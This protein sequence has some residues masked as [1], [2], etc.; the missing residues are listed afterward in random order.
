MST[1]M[2]QR[3]EQVAVYIDGFNLYFGLVDKGWRQYL[4]LDLCA[5]CESLLKPTQ[6][7]VAAKYFTTRVG[8]PPESVERQAT[9]LDALA[10]TG[11]IEIIYGN[12]IWNPQE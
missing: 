9:Y 6:E 8:W 2:P 1:Q 3:R 12:F 11:G 4:W 5:M 10:A 7:L